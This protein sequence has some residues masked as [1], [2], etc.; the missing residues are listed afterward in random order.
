MESIQQVYYSPKIREDVEF[1][2]RGCVVFQQN[3][4]SNKEPAGLFKTLHITKQRWKHVTMDLVC[5]IAN[6]LLE[7]DSMVG[8]CTN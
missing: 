7:H 1:Y 5:D 3:K 2:V 8:L 6:T 4:T